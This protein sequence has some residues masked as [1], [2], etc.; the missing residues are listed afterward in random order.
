MPDCEL[1]QDDAAGM[2]WSCFFEAGDD[3]NFLIDVYF[4]PGMILLEID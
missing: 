3:L 2:E 4:G 1:E